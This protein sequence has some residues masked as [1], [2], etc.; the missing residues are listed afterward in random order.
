[1]GGLGNAS[2]GERKYIPA[3]ARA[4]VAA[5]IDALFMEVHEDPDHALSDGPN[6]LALENFEGLLRCVKQIDALVR[7]SA[8]Q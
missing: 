3:L 8:P 6:S 7:G 5:G 1:P 2:G 4:G